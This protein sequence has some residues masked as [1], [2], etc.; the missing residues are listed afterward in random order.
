MSLL[1]GKIYIPPYSGVRL[2][3]CR[4]HFQLTPVAIVRI[5]YGYGKIEASKATCES[6]DGKVEPFWDNL[7]ANE[8]VWAVVQ[9]YRF[10]D[11][12]EEQG[13]IS[14]LRSPNTEEDARKRL[15][16][17]EDFYIVTRQQLLDLTGCFEA[18]E[19]DHAYIED[20]YP[21][22]QSP[23]SDPK[24]IDEYDVYQARLKGWPACSRKRL[25]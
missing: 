8:E 24:A 4:D 15:K 18:T 14:Y 21:N 22:Y 12:H 23:P 2:V 13:S 7:D 16:E 25:S 6:E 3:E 20:N 1:S 17:M 9:W 10:E 11:G 19:D 5:L